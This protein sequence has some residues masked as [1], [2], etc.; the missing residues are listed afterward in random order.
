MRQYSTTFSRLA[1]VRYS[2]LSEADV[3]GPQPRQF[4]SLVTGVISAVSDKAKIV[5]ATYTRGEIPSIHGAHLRYS[6]AEG[7]NLV[8][9]NDLPS[10]AASDDWECYCIVGAGKTSI[11]AVIW[12]LNNGVAAEH[13]KWIT[14][15]DSWLLVREAVTPPFFFDQMFTTKA[16]LDWADALYPTLDNITHD[17]SCPH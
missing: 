12:L 1:A 14:P 9:I 10:R 13:I 6:V 7:V 4:K 2:P 8:P 15:N 5:D 17:T 11:D 3:D 16:L